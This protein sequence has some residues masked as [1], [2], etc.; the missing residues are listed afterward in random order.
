MPTYRGKPYQIRLSN[1][2][3][4][5]LPRSTWR[6]YAEK[7]WIVATSE[8]V[9]RLAD[10]ME[11]WFDELGCL[12][13]LNTITDEGFPVPSSWRL[14]ENAAIYSQRGGS[15]DPDTR[16]REIQLM[17]MARANISIVIG[18]DLGR[19]VFGAE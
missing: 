13:M 3:K 6:E 17:A 5:R 10:H 16:Q 8:R 15:L 1:G 11:A 12:Q 9:A 19:T 18:A 4:H 2:D 7:G 14:V